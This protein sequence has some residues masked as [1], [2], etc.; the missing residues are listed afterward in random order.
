MNEPTPF[1][2]RTAH[3]SSGA[4]GS[5]DYAGWI[6]VAALV[7]GTLAAVLYAQRMLTRHPR[8]VRRSLEGRA[9][10]FPTPPHGDILPGTSV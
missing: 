4:A 6:A 7:G 1:R 3:G 8:P 5:G 2:P 9:A 10:S